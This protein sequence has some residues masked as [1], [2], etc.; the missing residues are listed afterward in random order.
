[1]GKKCYFEDTFCVYAMCVLFFGVSVVS[2]CI[3]V[4]CKLHTL[5]LPIYTKYY[6]HKKERNGWFN[7]NIKCI[8]YESKSTFL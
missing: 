2:Y 1:M 8:V 5:V 6:M 3:T 7:T 4:N